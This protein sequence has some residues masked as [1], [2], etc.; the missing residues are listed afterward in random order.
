MK[1]PKGEWIFEKDPPF[2]EDMK[3][4]RR[5]A[6][7]TERGGG[8]SSEKRNKKERSLKLERTELA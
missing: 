8:D 3:L 5:W 7:R 2:L 1:M 6:G 4:E